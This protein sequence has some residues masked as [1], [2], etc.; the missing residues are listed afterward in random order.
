MPHTD[1]DSDAGIPPTDYDSDDSIPHTDYGSGLA[2]PQTVGA[3]A[4]PPT[5]TEI[6]NAAEQVPPRCSRF[7]SDAAKTKPGSD[8]KST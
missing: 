5:A 8:S 2:T 6:S 7:L 1:Y 3:P 4:P